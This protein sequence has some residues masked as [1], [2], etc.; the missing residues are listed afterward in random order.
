MSKKIGRRENNDDGDLSNEEKE[1]E[2]KRGYGFLFVIKVVC[3]VLQNVSVRLSA[4][5]G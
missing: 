2:R 4:C 5:E 3:C 1:R